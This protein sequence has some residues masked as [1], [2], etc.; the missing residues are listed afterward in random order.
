MRC[1]VSPGLSA[2]FC[3]TASSKGLI[4]DIWY[5]ECPLLT[6]WA[7]TQAEFETVVRKQ[8]FCLLLPR[9]GTA[10]QAESRVD[11]GALCA[12][13]WVK[14]RGRSVE[15]D[16][17]LGGCAYMSAGIP[18][19]GEST[20]IFTIASEVLT[21]TCFIIFQAEST[22]PLVSRPFVHVSVHSH[23]HPHST[24]RCFAEQEG[25]TWEVLVYA[26]MLHVVSGLYYHWTGLTVVCCVRVPKG[27]C[28]SLDFAKA[29]KKKKSHQL[30]ICCK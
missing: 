24:M 9:A 17:L 29:L 13:Q 15:V 26:V 28:W 27:T 5:W 1:G 16:L 19:C 25:T 30:H 8:E 14:C 11:G 18:L 2:C 23:R 3:A 7:L 10:Q 22:P 4:V 6:G 21:P 20:I 12:A